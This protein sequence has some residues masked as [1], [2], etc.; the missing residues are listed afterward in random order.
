M[1]SER[2]LRGLNN[3]RRDVV[4]SLRE[5]G[6]KF[7]LPYETGGLGPG[8]AT[9]D[10]WILAMD[11]CQLYRTV[12]SLMHRMDEGSSVFDVRRYGYKAVAGAM[13]RLIAARGC[14]E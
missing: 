4:D 13:S 11:E 1:V 8:H 3:L 14:S 5:A 6:V 12:R 9:V 7:P 2:E 10:E